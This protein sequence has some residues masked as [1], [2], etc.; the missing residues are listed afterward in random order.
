[1]TGLRSQL[2]RSDGREVKPLPHG[3]AVEVQDPELSKDWKQ[4]F[5][6]STNWRTGQRALYLRCIIL[7]K[8]HCLTIL[9]S[10]PH[11]SCEFR[12]GGHS[13]PRPLL[14]K[15]SRTAARCLHQ[16]TYHTRSSCWHHYHSRFSNTFDLPRTH[17]YLTLWEENKP[18]S[19]A[20]AQK[21]LAA[22]Y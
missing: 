19:S 3:K 22:H 16:N 14:V 18:T 6:I 5:R 15:T 9:R 4:M 10:L 21:C 2:G 1:M 12:V 7:I 17:S 20:T 11:I 8:R 13:H